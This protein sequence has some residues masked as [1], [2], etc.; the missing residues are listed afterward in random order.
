[1]PN[2][3]VSTSLGDDSNPGSQAEPI[4][5]L[6]R[7]EQM[8][9]DV[10]SLVYRIR[11]RGEVYP[12]PQNGRN[13]WLR[14][15][16]YRGGRIEV[17]A[18]EAWDPNIYNTIESGVADAGT[19]SNTIVFSGLTPNAHRSQSLRIIGGTGVGGYKRINGNSAT[20]IE[21]DQPLYPAPVPGS[22]FEIFNFNTVLSLPV[23]VPPG[24]AYTIAADSLQS[25]PASLYAFG[26][27]GVTFIGLRIEGT[28][29]AA[30][31]AGSKAFQGVD[32]NMLLAF[33]NSSVVSGT[34]N[35]RVPEFGWGLRVTS[36][37]VNPT[38]DR[39][40]FEG[41]IH[42]DVGFLRVGMGSYAYMFGG[43]A[44]SIT[45][46]HTYNGAVLFFNSTSPF[47]LGSASFQRAAIVELRNIAFLPGITGTLLTLRGGVLV[48]MSATVT[49]ASEG[50]TTVNVGGASKLICT[51]A[52]A[53]GGAGDDWLVRGAPAAFNKSALSTVGAAVV[54]SD[55]SVATRST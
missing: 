32:T 6:E 26:D 50:P 42:Q 55:T 33:F 40:S 49:G 39:A 31:G 14:P 41:F 22:S 48:T 7:A 3:Y 35:N 25:T 29:T 45:P 34:Q 18:D 53:L 43:Y 37:P 10:V 5:T 20:H 1:M 38:L 2:I 12:L 9:P 47:Y 36:N 21:L 16:T 27:E 52:P 51:A 28:G 15:R 13:T 4:K 30:F 54:G 19:N 44:H 8:I 46:L 24:S 23:T 17:M 11:L